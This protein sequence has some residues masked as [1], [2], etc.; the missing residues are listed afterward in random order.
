MKEIIH[1]NTHRRQS[2]LQ[3][4]NMNQKNH[5]DYHKHSYGREEYR[6]LTLGKMYQGNQQ[7]ID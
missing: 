3:I 1:S 7:K 6:I 5:Q 2:H 4:C